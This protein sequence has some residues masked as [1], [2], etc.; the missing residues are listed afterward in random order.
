VSLPVGTVRRPRIDA[1]ITNISVAA[2]TIPTD[3]PEADGTLDWHATTIVVVEVE[4]G[5]KCGIG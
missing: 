4:G 5:G 2:Y 3:A 1:T